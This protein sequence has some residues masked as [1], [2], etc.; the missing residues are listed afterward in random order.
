MRDSEVLFLFCS[1]TSFLLRYRKLMTFKTMPT[2]VAMGAAGS[3]FH[4]CQIITNFG[5]DQNVK[6]KCQGFKEKIGTV[7]LPLT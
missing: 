3:A 1:C 2:V 4:R 6:R 7:Y 5:N